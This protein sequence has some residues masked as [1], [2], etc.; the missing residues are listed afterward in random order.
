MAAGLLPMT[1]IGLTP[2]F[3]FMPGIHDLILLLKDIVVPVSGRASVPAIHVLVSV[4][5]KS[6]HSGF[7]P[8]INRTF[9]AR[10]QCLIIFSR[11]IVSEYRHAVQNRRAASS[12]IAS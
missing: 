6:R 2:S 11:W 3:R 9:H 5:N 10:G 8:W 7:Y 1:A 12:H 4:S